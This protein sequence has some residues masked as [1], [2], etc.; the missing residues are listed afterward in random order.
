MIDIKKAY[1]RLHFKDPIQ[2]QMEKMNHYIECMKSNNSSCNFEEAF[3]YMRQTGK[4]TYKCVEAAVK[5]LNGE[6]VL[7]LVRNSGQIKNIEEKIK[8]YAWVLGTENHIK[9]CDLGKLKVSSTSNIFQ[10]KIET[11]GWSGKIIID[12]Y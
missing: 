2:F 9:Y 4:T 1:S 6:D 11:H 3:L 5:L 10:L 12:I 7:Y 8:E